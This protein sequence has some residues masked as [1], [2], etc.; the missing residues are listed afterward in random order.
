MLDMVENLNC[1]I[2]HT[3]AHF[4]I[5]S[6]HLLFFYTFSGN[7]KCTL[8]HTSETVLCLFMVNIIRRF[9]LEAATENKTVDLTEVQESF[10]LPVR[11]KRFSFKITEL[12]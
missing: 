4:I 6:N 11:P 3:K 9:K 1:W 7:R 8:H 5:I 12:L 10:H 2:S